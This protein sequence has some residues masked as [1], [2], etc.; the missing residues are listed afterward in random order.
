MGQTIWKNWALLLDSFHLGTLGTS[1]ETIFH[2]LQ[3]SPA[4]LCTLPYYTVFLGSIPH[5]QE[6]IPPQLHMQKEGA[7]ISYSDIMASITAR[8]KC[9]FLFKWTTPQT[10]FWKTFALC[11]GWGL[12]DHASIVLKILQFWVN[13]LLYKYVCLQ[14]TMQLNLLMGQE[15]MIHQSEPLGYLP[16]RIWRN[17]TR[18]PAVVMK[19]TCRHFLSI[20]PSSTLPLGHDN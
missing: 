1:L 2:V 14:E 15:K 11:V 6:A 16:D 4:L 13:I 20:T 12:E 3:P 18:F 8:M 7:L 9:Y 17:T 5:L 10:H 19:C